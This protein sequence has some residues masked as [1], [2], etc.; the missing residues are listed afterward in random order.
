MESHT[1]TGE[2]EGKIE[3]VDMIAGACPRKRSWLENGVTTAATATAR[4]NIYKFVSTHDML[5]QSV[6][7]YGGSCRFH[8]M[9]LD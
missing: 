4:I 5:L 8:R 3:C 9:T 6:A 1:I 7:S 2:H